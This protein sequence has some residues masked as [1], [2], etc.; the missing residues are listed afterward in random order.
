MEALT[1]LRPSTIHSFRWRCAEQLVSILFV[2]TDAM[3]ARAHPEL[4]GAPQ[5]A[6]AKRSLQSPRR[7]VLGK[8]LR[9]RRRDSAIST[10]EEISE[11]MGI[12]GGDD[13]VGG[14]G[15]VGGDGGCGGRE[16]CEAV[17]VV[18]LFVSYAIT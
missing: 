16:D 2:R 4:L 13:N 10:E 9:W 11:G 18:W 15:V 12:I 7:E 3:T 14:D 17:S 5:W 8:T 1:A 6:A